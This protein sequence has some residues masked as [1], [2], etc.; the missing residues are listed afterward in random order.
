MKNTVVVT[1]T[2]Y[3]DVNQLRFQLACQ[4][5]TKARIAG[6]PV[7]VVDGSPNPAIANRFRELGAVVYPEICKEIQHEDN[8]T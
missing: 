8:T 2:F 5:I 6:Y 3:K 4:M 1:T 7:I